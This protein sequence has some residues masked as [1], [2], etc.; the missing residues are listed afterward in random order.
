[1]QSLALHCTVVECAGGTKIFRLGF[2]QMRKNVIREICK[3]NA[4]EIIRSREP[5]KEAS[6]EKR[7]HSKLQSVIYNCPE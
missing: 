2:A 6:S 5:L 3:Y 4:T 7:A 1:M